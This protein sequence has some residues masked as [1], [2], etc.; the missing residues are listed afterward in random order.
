MKKLLLNP[1]ESSKDIIKINQLL[2]QISDFED[3]FLG[4][5]NKEELPNILI[6]QLEN[7]IISENPLADDILTN[8]DTIVV[9][10]A[11]KIID[12]SYKVKHLIL[13]DV[14]SENWLKQDIG[15]LYNAWVMQKKWDKETFELEDNIN[16]TKDRTA[17]ILYKLYLLGDEISLYSSVY[18]YLGAENFSG[19][20]KFFDYKNDEEADNSETPKVKPIKP[21]EDQ[22]EVLNYKGGLM[23]VSATAGSGKTT[24]LLLLVDKILSSSTT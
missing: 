18:D 11:Q 12:Y 22:K 23:S 17:R 19:I 9:S 16:L 24:I 1:L 5:L 15:P 14:S 13:A 10:S 4:S 6:N 20:D 3:V 21:R 8:E 7:T 2:K